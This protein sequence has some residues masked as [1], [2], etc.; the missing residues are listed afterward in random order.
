MSTISGEVHTVNW[1][2]WYSPPTYNAL[3]GV[4]YGNNCF[5]GVGENAT[6]VHADV[7][8]GGNCT[9][10]FSIVNAFQ[11]PII[12]FND[13]YYAAYLS[14]TVPPVVNA[15]YKLTNYE[16]VTDLVEFTDC[17]AT[18]LKLENGVY[19]LHVPKVYIAYYGA[20]NN[21]FYSAD[22]EY[23]PTTGDETWFKLTGGTA[24]Q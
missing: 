1:D 15:L 17:Q 19:K 14:G 23:V 9:T 8:L 24:Y 13:S 22:F 3:M 7:V 10:V 11:I 2:T 6:I 20:V 16:V 4:T 5:V 12:N 18:T 21:T